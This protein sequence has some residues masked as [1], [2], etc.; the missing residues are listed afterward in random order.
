MLVFVDESGDPGM[1]GKQG[2]SQLFV[3]AAVVFEENEEANSCDRKIDQLRL[4]CFRGRNQE[5]HFNKCSDAIRERFLSVVSQHDF[6]YLAFVLNKQK[7][8][9][10]GFSYKDSFYKF[11]AKLLFENAKPYL[12][13]AVVLNRS[14]GESGVSEAARKLSEGQDQ[15]RPADHQE[16]QNRTLALEQLAAVS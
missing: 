4:E 14:F 13:D 5:F 16:G 3:I 6:F 10:P 2:S 7:L 15:H 11:T 9:G 8:H 12:R 1:K